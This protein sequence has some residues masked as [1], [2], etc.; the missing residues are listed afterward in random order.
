MLTV[1]TNPHQEGKHQRSRWPAVVAEWL[2]RCAA[3]PKDAGSMTVM[4]AAFLVKAKT[5][6]VQISVH[7][8]DLQV[9]EMNLEPST[10]ASP[11]AQ[12]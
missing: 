4:V 8:K 6:C 5:P 11:I 2:R 1:E 9:V 10:T 12:V 7:I 3:E